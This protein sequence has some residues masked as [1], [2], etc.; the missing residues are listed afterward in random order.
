MS[1]SHEN[2]TS[3][4]NENTTS[5]ENENTTSS[6]EEPL[7]DSSR[8]TE[9]GSRPIAESRAQRLYRSA[10]R[11]IQ[12]RRNGKTDYLGVEGDN[13]NGKEEE[14]D[15]GMGRLLTRSLVESRSMSVLDE[16]DAYNGFAMSGHFSLR[17]SIHKTRNA[18]L[19]N[20]GNHQLIFEPRRRIRDK[21]VYREIIWFG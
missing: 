6:L 3:T 18:V 21:Y 5:T 17:S 4:E 2:T 15:S 7:L 10:L 20:E 9:S 16:I 12:S 1:D 11:Y 13:D 14:E 19:L 8:G